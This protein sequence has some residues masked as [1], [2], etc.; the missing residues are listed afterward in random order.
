MVIVQDTEE[1]KREVGESL[2]K[3]EQGDEQTRNFKYNWI[4]TFIEYRTCLSST[5]LYK[6]QH[7]IILKHKINASIFLS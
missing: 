7:T 6:S 2:M 4:C 1:R 5:Q 3:P